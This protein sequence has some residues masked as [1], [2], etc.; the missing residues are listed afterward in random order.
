[1]QGRTH[2]LA[3]WMM[4]VMTFPY[5]FATDSTFNVIVSYN[6]Q[7]NWSLAIL[8]L[9]LNVI[10]AIWQIARIR[11]HHLNPLKVELW[12]F[13]KKPSNQKTLIS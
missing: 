3:F 10:L 6:P 2:T 12:S 1:M 4:W 11:K 8:S 7:A 9:G 13:M 5:F